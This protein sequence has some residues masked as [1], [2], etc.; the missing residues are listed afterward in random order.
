MGDGAGAANRRLAVDAELGREN[1][2][3]QIGITAMEDPIGEREKKR[4]RLER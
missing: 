4:K 3:E 1:S 2:A